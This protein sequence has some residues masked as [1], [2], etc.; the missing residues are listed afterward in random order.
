MAVHSAQQKEGDVTA[1]W[2]NISDGPFSVLWFARFAINSSD[3]FW[4]PGER[5][6]SLA[7]LINI[8]PVPFSV[9]FLSLGGLSPARFH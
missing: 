8:G 9:R 1:F 4:S 7:H 3:P 5:S 2:A 6:T